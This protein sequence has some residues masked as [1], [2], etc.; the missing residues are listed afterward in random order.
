VTAADSDAMLVQRPAGDQS[1]FELLVIKYQRRIQRLRLDHEMV[2]VLI[3]RGH[4]ARDLY[5]AYR[6][7][8]NSERPVLQHGL[9]I[10]SQHRQKFLLDLKRDP[11]RV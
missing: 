4:C 8:I 5:L 3:C 2:Q 9:Q 11:H 7:C 1:A 6:H 10:V